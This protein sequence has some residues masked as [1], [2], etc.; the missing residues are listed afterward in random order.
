MEQLESLTLRARA[1]PSDSALPGS[2]HL[3]ALSVFGCFAGP[4]ALE[5]QS[6]V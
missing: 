2:L 3:G 4:S 5:R 6:E 1:T